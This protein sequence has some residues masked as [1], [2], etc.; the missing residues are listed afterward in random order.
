MYY[1]LPNQSSL[2]HWFCHKKYAVVEREE[3][4]RKASQTL[5]LLGVEALSDL[6]VTVLQLTHVSDHHSA[7]LKPLHS[8]MCIRAGKS[9][10]SV[11]T[12]NPQTPRENPG[13]NQLGGRVQ[14]AAGQQPRGTAEADVW[15]SRKREA[16][17]PVSPVTPRTVVGNIQVTSRE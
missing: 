7:H 13:E 2:R 16:G 15:A 6:T 4:L 8:H 17:A 12:L 10:N 14:G 11:S 3:N 1:H 9:F 5:C